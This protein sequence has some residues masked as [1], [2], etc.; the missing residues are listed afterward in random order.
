MYKENF[1]QEKKRNVDPPR[2]LHWRRM[3]LQLWPWCQRDL[4]S[5]FPI[6]ADQEAVSLEMCLQQVCLQRCVSRDVSLAG[7]SLEIRSG[8][9]ATLFFLNI[10]PPLLLLFFLFLFVGASLEIRSGVGASFFSEILAHLSCFYSSCSCLSVLLQRSDQVSLRLQRY[11]SSNVSLDIREQRIYDLSGMFIRCFD[12]IM[13]V[14][15]GGCD[16]STR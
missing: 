16:F 14:C 6:A 8:V 11:V 9:G 4:L 5:S 13:S 7:V 2:L 1:R 15:F 3:L 12:K 10:G